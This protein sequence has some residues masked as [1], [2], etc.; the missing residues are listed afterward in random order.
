MVPVGVVLARSYLLIGILNTAIG[1]HYK[2]KRTVCSRKHLNIV[3]VRMHGSDS[4]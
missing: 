1:C 4:G 2:L 3:K